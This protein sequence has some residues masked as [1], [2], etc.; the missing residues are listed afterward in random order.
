MQEHDGSG[1]CCVTE[2]VFEEGGEV[3]EIAEVV[4]RV[5]G[6]MEGGLGVVGGAETQLPLPPHVSHVEVWM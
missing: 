1:T 2:P 5:G 4:A 3:D 6:H